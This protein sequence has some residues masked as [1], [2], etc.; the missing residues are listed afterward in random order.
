[1][2]DQEIKKDSE[3]E[4]R[5]RVQLNAKSFGVVAYAEANFYSDDKQVNLEKSMPMDV[6]AF[7]EELEKAFNEKLKNSVAKVKNILAGHEHGKENGKC[8]YQCVVDLTCKGR[9]TKQPGVLEHNGVKILYMFQETMEHKD[10]VRYC[11]KEKNYK[12]LRDTRLVFVFLQQKLYPLI[13][14]FVLLIELQLV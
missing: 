7:M 6:D 2:I 1:M 12:W 11:K 4:I 14:F 8:H 3:Q 9:I 10:L 13:F 5:K